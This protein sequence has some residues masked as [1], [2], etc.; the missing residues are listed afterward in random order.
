MPVEAK[1]IWS[2]RQVAIR[3]QVSAS[4]VARTGCGGTEARE[5]LETLNLKPTDA[6][7]PDLVFW[8]ESGAEGSR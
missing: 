2:R 8:R 4:K 1:S 6:L 3:F 7:Q 5:C